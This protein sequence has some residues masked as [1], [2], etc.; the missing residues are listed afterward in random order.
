VKCRLN[1]EFVCLNLGGQTCLVAQYTAAL[2]VYYIVEFV[3]RKPASSV[4]AIYQIEVFVAVTCGDLVG[5]LILYAEYKGL[6]LT[7]ILCTYL[8]WPMRSTHPSHLITLATGE[9]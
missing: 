3:Y 5:C 7:K 4:H 8:I 1:F 9:G 2:V 6:T